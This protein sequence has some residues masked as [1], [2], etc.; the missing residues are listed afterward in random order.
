MSVCVITACEK[1]TE[2]NSDNSD[3]ISIAEHGIEYIAAPQGCEIVSD[4]D[5]FGSVDKNQTYDFVADFNPD[6]YNGYG[7]T[8]SG[9]IMYT[10]FSDQNYLTYYNKQSGEN[11]LLCAKPDCNHDNTACNAYL[12]FGNGLIYYDGFLYTIKEEDMSFIKIACDGTTRETVRSLLPVEDGNV[13][14]ENDTFYTSKFIIHKGYVYYYYQF[15]SGMTEDTYYLNGSNCIW[16]A[17]LDGTGEPECIIPAVC[18]STGIVINLKGFGSYIY[19]NI[20]Q[21]NTI[22]GS[23]YRYNIE[24][25]K[26][27]LLSDIGEDVYGYTVQD[28]KIY[29]ANY[30]E[31]TDKVFCYD[32]EN[33]ENKEFVE[34]SGNDGWYC[35][36]VYA[37]N[38]SLYFYYVT[39]DMSDSSVTWGRLYIYDYEGN[40]QTV[41]FLA[42]TDNNG[43]GVYEL[44]C[45]MDEDRIYLSR[46]SSNENGMIQRLCYMKKPEMINGI[47]D[48]QEVN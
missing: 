45:G 15:Y 6:F 36:F 12:G 11:G 43:N 22:G 30:T 4:A 14:K 13:D 29:Y 33:Y 21:K 32:L 5:A 39:D 25:D 7:V 2:K 9:N 24:S 18:E 48:I 31:Q 47:C 27:E 42:K 23:L 17:A 41:V 8:D 38:D 40:E 28:N 34:I 35:S 1:R 19:M 37:D 26:V 3:L 10:F 16:K 20:P 44:L 46:Q